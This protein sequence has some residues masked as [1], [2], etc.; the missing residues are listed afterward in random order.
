MGTL[1]I[2]PNRKRP[3]AVAAV[4]FAVA[5]ALC[6][7]SSAE[8][9]ETTDL[10]ARLEEA[11]LDLVK[12]LMA[13]PVQKLVNETPFAVVTKRA[14]EIAQTAQAV[15]ATSDFGEDEEFRLFIRELEGTARHLEQAAKAKDL[16]KSSSALLLLQRACLSCHA[17]Y[18]F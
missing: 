6:A 14:A 13:V 12:S 8:P 9:L 18:R 15:P 16:N 3:L 17:E 10:M 4:L 5:L 11:Y 1:G 7:P 2:R